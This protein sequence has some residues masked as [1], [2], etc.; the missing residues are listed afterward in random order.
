VWWFNSSGGTDIC[1]AFCTGNRELPESPGKLQCRQLGAAVEAWNEQGEAV[2]DEVGELVCTKP[3][4]NM[5]LFLW[6]DVD[7]TRYRESY[8][9]P[10]PGVWRHGDWLKI[11]PDGTCE[12]YGRSD[13]TINRGGHR[14]GTS[15]IY[16]AI[17]RLEG[18]ADS[19][20]VD[21]RVDDADSILLLF[22]VPSTADYISEEFAAHLCQA[23]RVS[24]SPRFV[25]D[26]VIS[27]SAIPRTLSS[28]K[29]ELPIKQLLEGAP[30]ERVVEP[31]AMS[32]PE[33]L[34]EYVALAARFRR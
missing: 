26:Q 11:E 16:A 10:Y 21:V 9:E 31:A 25:P 27:V 19:L 12:I 18:V 7:G 32:N 8:F 23:I 24:L 2:V 4:P 17:E 29:L 13:A 30:I 15:E 22:V 34:A 1:G 14:M 20:V 28:K 3:L 33:C 5:P 6:G